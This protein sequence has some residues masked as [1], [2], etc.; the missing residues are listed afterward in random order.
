MR[1]FNLL[2][3][4]VVF[5]GAYAQDDYTYEIKPAQPSMQ[6][7]KQG[8]FFMGFNLSPTISWLNIDHNDLHTDGATIT[9]GF[10]LTAEYYTG[11]IF[12]LVS[13]I[14]FIL[15][16]GYAFDSRS[17]SDNNT[18]N[19]FRINY[20]AIEVPVLLRI[21]TLPFEKTT[22]Y[23]QGGISA[24]YRFAASEFHRAASFESADEKKDISHLIHPSLLNLQVGFGAKFRFIKKY[25]LFAEVNYKNSI[26]NIA[27]E[28]GY[29]SEGR[30]PAGGI[31]TILNG[32]MIF[33]V[34]VLF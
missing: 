27:D 15:P 18:K 11:R 8:E 21:N 30:Y 14:N 13:G 22:Y 9:G 3:L 5:S 20:P 19:N 2:I 1:N 29:L 6:E 34:G 24:A 4:L 25:Y 23:A 28:K 10:G 16:G 32:N 17:L 12:S 31:P 33:S 7:E 26:I